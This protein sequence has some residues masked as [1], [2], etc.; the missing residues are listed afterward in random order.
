MT[1]ARRGVLWLLLA[2]L[3]LG[4]GWS[5][6]ILSLEEAEYDF[7]VL[8]P[9]QTVSHEFTLTNTGD[10]PLLIREARSTCGCAVALPPPDPIPPGGR[11]KVKV[12]LD[13]RGYRGR[14]TKYV[15]LIS[16]S[17]VEPTRRLT[18]HAF[19]RTSEAK[20]S[21]PAKPQWEVRPT[22]WDFGLVSLGAAP[23]HFF[24]VV[25]GG[26]N[27]VTVQVASVTPGL[28]ASWPGEVQLAPKQR[29]LLP[30]AFEPLTTPGTVTGE[31]VLAADDPARPW[32]VL[33]VRGYVTAETRPRLAVLPPE[34]DLGLLAPTE[35]AET[36]LWLQNVG[37]APLEIASVETSSPHLAARLTS[38]QALPPQGRQALRLSFRPAAP[39]GEEPVTG[40]IQET[41]TLRT[42]DPLAPEATISVSG[43]V[44]PLR[45]AER[46]ADLV[47][48]YSADDWG[49]IEPCG[50]YEG[51]LGG[52]ARR[53]A[54][55]AG[56]RREVPLRVLLLHAGDL[57]G[58]GDEAQARLKARLAVKAFSA[59]GYDAVA[60]GENDFRFGREFWEDALRRAS[61]AAVNTNL[62]D[63]EGKPALGRPYLVKQVG[64]VRVGLLGIFGADLELPP[65]K[66]A[67]GLAVHGPEEALRRYLPEVR[68]QADYII[69]LAHTGYARA[70]QL[71]QAV[72]G[73]DL[74]IVGHG[75][76]RAR[77][78]E[79]VGNTW[80]VEHTDQG[81]HLGRLDLRREGDGLR[82]VRHWSLPV[83]EALPEEPA[84][85]RL[86]RDYKKRLR[87]ALPPPLPP[88]LL[89]TDAR[90]VGADTCERCHTSAM[91]VWMESAHAQAFSSLVKRQSAYDPECVPCHTTGYRKANGFLRNDLTPEWRDV[92]CEAC[93]GPGS[94]HV[95]AP[96]RPYPVPPDGAC[97]T[98]HTPERSP[99]YQFETYWLAIKH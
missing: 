72:S 35:T 17:A 44:R 52:L 45:P 53:A 70:W 14:L 98:C 47:I 86:V 22:Q 87:E 78:P 21:R 64:E 15:Y 11:I 1:R 57:F 88:S 40:T 92:Q 36:T 30:V 61:F 69:L 81:K 48:L 93:H 12:S 91:Q 29:E 23:F 24:E 75:T 74:V 10:E 39:P 97:T 99:D 7:G 25:N 43:Y 84:V 79:R 38:S 4:P 6:P 67:L 83:A 28:R 80:L 5:G 18:L 65:Q 42:N 51:Q 31:V 68:K 82:V 76:G 59:M 55:I 32:Q 50:C 2:A 63:A 54:L 41:V 94:R 9:G 96:L 77:V 27:P 20:S 73:L 66:P 13:T 56:V 34:W 89:P 49:E 60:L 19:V 90:Y 95:A 16:N 62:V 58:A 8:S 3:S 46:P 85:A 37:T 33:T 26:E 71:A